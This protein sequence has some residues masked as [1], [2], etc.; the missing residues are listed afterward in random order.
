MSDCNGFLSLLPSGLSAEGSGKTQNSLCKMANRWAL[1]QISGKN[2][3]GHLISSH[4]ITTL[5]IIYS[6]FRSPTCSGST[7][8]QPLHIESYHLYFPPCCSNIRG[9]K[10]TAYPVISKAFLYIHRPF[11]KNTFLC[12]LL[13]FQQETAP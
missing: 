1:W 10:I 4:C 11:L 3:K 9:D 7:E 12:S 6:Q 8:C 5:T 2:I 13:I